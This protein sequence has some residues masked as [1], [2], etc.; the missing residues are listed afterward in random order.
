M[1]RTAT[2][3]APVFRADLGPN[4]AAKIELRR[5]LPGHN[6]NI[7]EIVLKEPN[8]ADLID[9]GHLMRRILHEPGSA[10]MRL[11]LVDDPAAL[12]RWMIRLSGQHEAILRLMSIPDARAVQSEVARIVDEFNVGGNSPASPTT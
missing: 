1:Q 12:M 2:V 6:G 5:P 7:T 9:C 4:V 10:T 8:L 11:E 3:E